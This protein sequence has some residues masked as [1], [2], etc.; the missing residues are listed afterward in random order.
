MKTEMVVEMMMRGQVE[1]KEGH[2]N[3]GH[4]T[5]PINERIKTDRM[6]KTN[7]Q[8][9]STVYN[10]VDALLC[11]SFVSCCVGNQLLS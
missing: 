5:E 11:L 3:T 10:S 6:N 9:S 7:Y 2:N 1:L 4:L 8:M